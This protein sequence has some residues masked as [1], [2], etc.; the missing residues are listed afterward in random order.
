MGV[1]YMLKRKAYNQLINWKLKSKGKTALLVE[2]A[3]RVGKST[4][5]EEFGKKEY[6]SYILIDFANAS[7]K[8]IDIFDD[9][10]N[11]NIFFIRLQAETKINLYERN[12]LI[13]FDEV[14]L[15]PKARQAIKYLVK[16]GRYDYIETGSLISIK[17]NIQN[18]LIPSEEEKINLFPLDYEEFQWATN[19]NYE[20]LRN[21]FTNKISIGDSTNNKLNRDFRIYMSIGGMPQAVEAYVNSNNLDEIDKL[22]RNII[23]LYEDDF[24]KIDSTGILSNMYNSIPN[25]LTA[26]KIKFS[27]P[28]FRSDRNFEKLFELI[29]SKTV[30][31][32]QHINDPSTFLTSS[33]DIN[34]F[35]LYISDVGLLVTMLFNSKNTNYKDIYNKLWSNTLDDNLGYLYE[36]ALAQIM[37]SSGCNLYY[38]TW[39]KENSTHSYE[40]DFLTARNN[41]LIPIEVKSNKI[42]PHN[43]LSAFINKYSRFIGKKIIISQKDQKYIDDIR[44][45]PFYLAPFLFE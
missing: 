33:I 15:F 38:H 30:L 28:H 23:K 44:N 11:L 27:L 34:K 8:I 22:K 4:L 40:I 36:N 35:K 9:I 10:S 5:V 14:Q 13:I 20:V 18:I 42:N 12:S 31:A 25:Q 21:L 37:T 17:K 41:K 45:I 19:G 32:C 39:K 1:L 26:D 7:K 6:K 2:G 24:R 43:S 3:R 29:D 16:D